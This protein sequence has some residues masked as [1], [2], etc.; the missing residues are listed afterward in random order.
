[1]SSWSGCPAVVVRGMYAWWDSVQASVAR[2]GEGR[3][4]NEQAV[5]APDEAHDVS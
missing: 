1:M 3:M 5:R 2:L 4:G